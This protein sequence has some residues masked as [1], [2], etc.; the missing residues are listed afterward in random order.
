MELHR[1]HCQ[2]CQSIEMR[3]I[4]VREA[5]KATSVYVRC[6][7]C[8]ELVARYKLRDYYHHGRN[9]IPGEKVQ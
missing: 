4:L 1:Q 6:G 9:Y 7:N 2:N 5:G 3:N 8:G